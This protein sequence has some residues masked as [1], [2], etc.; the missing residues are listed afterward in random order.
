[1]DRKEYEAEMRRQINHDNGVAEHE[2]H[3]DDIHGDGGYDV[4][5]FGQADPVA[6]MDANK[7]GHSPYVPCP[8]PECVFIAGHEGVCSDQTVPTGVMISL[9]MPQS[10]QG[11]RCIV[12]AERA[13]ER[14]I[15]RNKDYGDEARVLGLKGQYS[16]LNR[17][18]IKLKRIM[19]DDVEPVNESLEEILQD[20]LGNILLTLD[21]MNDEE[22]GR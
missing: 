6:K 15:Q 20:L 19:W 11:M 18:I 14:F 2:A 16:D 10:E 21:M 13:L 22:A 4:H 3:G 1:M 12:I 17:K 8:N 7:T 5:V 9:P